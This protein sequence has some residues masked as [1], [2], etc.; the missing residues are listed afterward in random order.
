MITSEST[1]PSTSHSGKDIHSV[2]CSENYLRDFLL[3]QIKLLAHASAIHV[4]NIE[5]FFAL[6]FSVSSI[7]G[8]KKRHCHTPGSPDSATRAQSNGS[9]RVRGP[10]PCTLPPSSSTCC[11]LATRG[12]SPST[13]R[14]TTSDG[15]PVS[16]CNFFVRF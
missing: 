13:G 11:P 2:H 8:R 14:L 6:Y 15:P 3:Q 10:S 7:S 1:K 5:W 12:A 9:T 4:N 16:C